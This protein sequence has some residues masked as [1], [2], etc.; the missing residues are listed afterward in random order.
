LALNAYVT[1]RDIQARNKA[2]EVFQD[3]ASKDMRLLGKGVYKVAPAMD[4]ETVLWENLGTPKAFKIKRVAATIA[5]CVS[6]F[7]LS[8]AGIWGI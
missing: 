1:F 4:P 6:I 5:F 3:S 2:L 7:A 8:L